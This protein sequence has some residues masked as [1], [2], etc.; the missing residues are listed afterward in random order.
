L[1]KKRRSSTKY[2]QFH[3][4]VIDL[5]TNNPG[6]R[7]R[8]YPQSLPTRCVNTSLNRPIPNQRATDL[9]PSYAVLNL[10]PG[11][12]DTQIKAQYRTLSL[13]IHPDKTT[14][15]L[16]PNAFDRLKKASSVL[17]DEK[18]RQHL[19]SCIADARSLLIRQRKL[20]IDSPE[21]KEPNEDF[22]K[23]WRELTKKVLVE[24]ELRR[25]KQMKA[26]MQ[27]E[28]RE[29][30]KQDEEV[31]QRKRRRE[32]ESKWEETREGRIGSWRDFKGGKKGGGG[33]GVGDGVEGGKKKKQKLKV[34][35]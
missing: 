30:R 5:T 3:Y 34:L 4:S 15:P 17:L 7:N 16:A 29:Q 13:L 31:D 18:P 10:Q 24:E 28:G 2:A 12:P 27:E 33:G 11:I 20:T 35:G 1:S 32:Y 19:D 25:K 23:E 9:I 22:K 26:Q 21:V 6:R 8:S 14:N